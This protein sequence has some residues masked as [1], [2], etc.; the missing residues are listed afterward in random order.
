MGT[1]GDTFNAAV[2]AEL[3]GQRARTRMTVDAVTAGTG[4]AKSTVLNYLNGKRDIPLPALAELCR[5]LRVEPRAIFEA[6]QK[7][8]DDE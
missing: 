4:F 6:A 5:V 8:I 7:A 3:R 1:Y 2:A